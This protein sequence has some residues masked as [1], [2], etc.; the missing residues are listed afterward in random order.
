MN[1]RDSFHALHPRTISQSILLLIVPLWLAACG[2]GAGSGDI[3]TTPPSS[4][5][6][7]TTPT[8]SL[9]ANSTTV[10]SGGAT[11]LTW[12]ATNATSCTASGDWSGSKSASGSQTFSALTS[13]KTY[14]LTCTGSGG[15]DSRSVTVTIGTP[16]PT[17]SLA[18][19]PVFVNANGSSTLA[20]S[21]M[22]ASTCTASGS[23]TGAKPTS[24]SQSAGPIA[25][26]SSYTLSC[27]G[28]GGS[29][30]RTVTVSVGTPPPVG[31][32]TMPTLEDERN[33]YRSWG[34]TW[35]SDKEPGAVTEPISNYYVSNPDIH[36]STEGDDL[37]TYI[38]M[39]QRTG[40]TMYLNRAKAWARYFKEDYRQCIGDSYENYCYDR[41]AYGLDHVYGWGLVEWYRYTCSQGGCDTAALTAAENLG[42]DV[43]AY[44]STR[45][46]GTWPVPGQFRMSYYAPRGGARHLILISHLAEA[47]QA[48][49]WIT[50]RDK[51][52]DLWMQSPDWDPRGMYFVGDYQTDNY[53][54]KAGAYAAGLRAQSTFQIGILSEALFQAYRGTGRTDIRDRIVAMARFVDQYGLDSTYQYAGSWFG[55]LNGN[56]W[57]NYSAGG[58]PT[59][60]DPTYTTSLVNTLVLGYKFSGDRALYDRA[61]HFFNRG[62]KSVYGSP[63]A[64]SS[65]DNVVDHFVDTKFAFDFWLAY[66]KGELQY[67]YLIFENGGL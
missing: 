55:L 59:F 38:H 65:P 50:L 36:G 12:S 63:T 67:T 27:T 28:T 1:H 2:G 31:A 5:D 16:V 7:S 39:Y 6:P 46:N 18:A 10:T 47:T 19:N 44:W 52:I 66:N 25:A 42:S 48:Q 13:S 24:G 41:D 15:S 8:V 9:S 26:T 53:V 35:T 29:T 20:W 54:D 51:L 58:I 37:W 60:W 23:W 21:S 4:T 56:P 3:G 57:H 14:T 30:S 33:T 11:T 22:N 34:W 62:T 43:E 40:N 45:S 61:K 64:R 32:F 17:V 49:R